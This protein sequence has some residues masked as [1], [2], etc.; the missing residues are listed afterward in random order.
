[1]VGNVRPFEFPTLPN[2]RWVQATWAGIENLLYPEMIERGVI[3]SNV[4]GQAAVPMSEHV[5][6]SILYLL[7]DF[8]AFISSRDDRNWRPTNVN[9]RLLNGSKVLVLGVGAISET[10]IPM[11]NALGA[12]VIGVNTSGKPVDGCAEVYTLESVRDHLSDI[13]MVVS[14]LPNTPLTKG[15][16]DVDFF[17]ALQPGAGIVNVSRGAVLN[18]DDLLAAIESEQLC[19]AVLDVTSP[20]P[21]LATSPLWDNPRVLLTGHRS[22]APGSNRNMWL[23]V[24]LH[25]LRCYRDGKLDDMQCRVNPELGY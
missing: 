11:L 7:R 25:N 20:E 3:I 8:P 16:L 13:G 14:L 4:R 22:Y 19:G 24:F 1:V 21:P 6:G 17:N 9:M 12:T 10:L 23:D 5:L 2:L 15:Y 18:E